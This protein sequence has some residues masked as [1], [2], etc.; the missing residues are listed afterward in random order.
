[1]YKVTSDQGKLAGMKRDR[2]DGKQDYKKTQQSL[3]VDAT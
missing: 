3:N 1:M 2:K